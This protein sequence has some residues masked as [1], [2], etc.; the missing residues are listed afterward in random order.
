MYKRQSLLF[1]TPPGL[2]PDWRDG[3]KI[4]E[5]AFDVTEALRD[6]L[7]KEMGPAT[8]GALLGGMEQQ[9][10]REALLP[11]FLL[12]VPERPEI[13]EEMANMQRLKEAAPEHVRWRSP[14]PAAA[15]PAAVA[16]TNAMRVL[17]RDWAQRNSC[18]D[19]G[20]LRDTA[21]PGSASS[22]KVDFLTAAN[23][24]S[25][26]VL[27]LREDTAKRDEYRVLL[28]SFPYITI[29]KVGQEQ[30]ETPEGRAKALG[31]LVDKHSGEIVELDQRQ[32]RWTIEPVASGSARAASSEQWH[33]CEHRAEAGKAEFEFGWPGDTWQMTVERRLEKKCF[34][35]WAKQ[36]NRVICPC[37]DPA[38]GYEWA[39]RGT[40]LTLGELFL[41]LGREYAAAEIYS[42]YRTL[43]I[44]ALKRRKQHR[45]R[46]SASSSATGVTHSP[47]QAAQMGL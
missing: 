46:A 23:T 16:V 41:A 32:T 1:S 36:V 29:M 9:E 8:A 27:Q 7:E 33:C 21:E 2:K 43:R 5:T 26:Q 30:L 38:C 35:N 45:G 11:A 42:F 44:V 18:P 31:Q 17:A 25:L 40:V 39:R 13:N 6:D 14:T 28:A 3:D 24:R 47:F 10:V 34:P 22:A 37:I 12:P 20:L 15:D 4:D 19:L